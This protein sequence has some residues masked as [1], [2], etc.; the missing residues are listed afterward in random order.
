MG[1]GRRKGGL[2]SAPK[3]PFAGPVNATSGS[4]FYR[5]LLDNRRYWDAELAAEGMMQLSS[6]PSPPSTNGTF[7]HQQA[8]HSIVRSMITRS[9]TWEPRYGVCPGF[10][11]ADFYG[12]QD[13]FTSTATAALEFGAMVYARGVV[14]YQFKHYVRADGMIWFRAEEARPAERKQNTS[15]AVLAPPNPVSRPCHHLCGWIA[16]TR[17][18]PVK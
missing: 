10:G 7:L 16:H 14:D 13:V 1:H 4:A 6:L 15:H 5:T 11:A 2:T 18:N 12:L 17:G 9:N 8:V 3:R